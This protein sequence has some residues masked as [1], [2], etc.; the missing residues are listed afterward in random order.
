MIDMM[1]EKYNL[2]CS[3][4]YKMPFFTRLEHS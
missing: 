3:I 4:T 1:F 2:N